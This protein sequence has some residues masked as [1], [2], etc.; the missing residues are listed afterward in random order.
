[1][2]T[3]LRQGLS[4]AEPPP[5]PRKLD[6]EDVFGLLDDLVDARLD[7]L[8]SLLDLALALRLRVVGHIADFLLRLAFKTLALSAMACPLESWSWTT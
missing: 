2:L 8:T 3:R 5:S 4:E 1:M 6:L 7:L